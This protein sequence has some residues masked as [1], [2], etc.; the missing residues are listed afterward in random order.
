MILKDFF[1]AA[2]TSLIVCSIFVIATRRSI[3][4][5]GFMWFYLIVLIATWAGG[6]WLRPFGPS[7]G[8]VRWLQ[9]L[10]IGLLIVL[11]FGLSSPP[12]APQSRH[13][14]IDR[15]EE[16]ARR[17]EF[18]TVTYITLGIVFWLVVAILIAAIVIRYVIE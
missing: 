8:N 17:K 2:A 13:E 12:K 7:L 9:F 14:T 3:R 10:I 16:I 18:E 5:S 15:L 1:F 4:R 6:V 11:L